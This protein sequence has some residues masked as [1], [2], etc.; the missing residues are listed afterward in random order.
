MGRD[1][2]D[3]GDTEMKIVPLT[4]D[5]YS[6]VFEALIRAGKSTQKIRDELDK[7]VWV[8]VIDLHTEDG[9]GIYIFSKES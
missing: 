5:Q 8:Q 9:Q 4:E 6:D 7:I 3:Q 2:E 1:R